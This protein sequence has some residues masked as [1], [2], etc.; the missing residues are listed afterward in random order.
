MKRQ[1]IE[2]GMEH[3]GYLFFNNTTTYI[4]K[5]QMLGRVA[6][7]MKRGKILLLGHS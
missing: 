7:N 4:S 2:K 6:R 3:M 1:E 5:V